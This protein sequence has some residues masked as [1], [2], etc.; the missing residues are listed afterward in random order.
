ME[1]RG[2]LCARQ[3]RSLVKKL[4]G[5]LEDEMKPQHSMLV[6]MMM[7]LCSL[8]N[9]WSDRGGLKLNIGDKAISLEADGAPLE[10]IL[11]TLRSEK[12]I[13]YAGPESTLKMEVTAAF[14]DK[15][16][17]EAVKSIMN[18]IDYICY[19]GE[20]GEIVG[21]MVIGE[22]AVLSRKPANETEKESKERTERLLKYRV[23]SYDERAPD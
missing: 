1:R 19:Y 23:R 12:G 9:A 2:R 6:I 7:V 3:P 8:S 10:D 14:K 20:R 17:E 11:E 18:S 21:V 4:K 16:L 15:S 13:W 5:V 22:G